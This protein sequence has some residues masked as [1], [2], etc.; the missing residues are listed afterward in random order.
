MPLNKIALFASSSTGTR[1]VSCCGSSCKSLQRVVLRVVLSILSAG[2]ALVSF[3]WAQ[4]RPSTQ[5][6]PLGENSTARWIEAYRRRPLTFEVNRG[7]TDSRVRFLSRRG[8]F[9]LFL[10]SNQAVIETVKPMGTLTSSAAGGRSILTMTWMGANRHPKIEGIG[11]TQG[12]TNYLV[13]N[14]PADWHTGIPSYTRVQYHEIYRGVDVTYYSEGSQLEYDLLLSPGSHPE[15]IGLRFS[16]AANPRLSPAGDL[17]LN[18]GSGRVVLH[19]PVV[20]QKT[21]SGREIISAKYVLK[22]RNQIGFKIGTYNHARALVIDPELTYSSYLGGSGDDDA[23]RV[24]VDPDGNA[25]LVGWSTSLDFP[26]ANPFQATAAGSTNA[27]I[28]KLNPEL[29]GSASLVYSTYLGGSG[30]NIGRGVAVDS[31][32][33]VY[34]SG[35]TNAADFPVTTGAYQTSCKLQGGTCSTDVFATKLNAA[36]NALLYSTYVGGSGTEFGFVVAI[37]GAGHIFLGGNTDSSDFPVT[38]GAYQTTF[39]GGPANYGDAFVAELNPAGNGASDLLYASYLGGSG[40][41]ATWGIAVDSLGSVYLAGSTTSSDFPVT[42]S[43]YQSTYSGGSSSVG[44]GFIAKLNPAGLGKS[45]LMYSTF[46]GGSMDDRVEGIALDSS[47]LVYVTGYTQ[48]SDFPVTPATAFQPTFGGGACFGAPCADA[49]I[50]KLDPSEFGSSS[51]LYS[52]FFG[53]SS[54]DL[55]HAIALDSTGL[56][57][58]TGETT[59]TDL[60]LTNPIQTQCASGCTPL[61]LT[62]VLIAKLDLSKPGTS[63]LLFSTYLGGND[64]DTGWSIAADSKGNAYVAGQLYSTNFPTVIPYQATCNGCSSFIGSSPSGDGFL[65]K[66]CT[67][68]CPAVSLSPASLTFSSQ[69]VETTSP[70]QELTLTNS[71]SGDLTVASIS[72]AGSN[73]EDFSQN[74][75]CPVVLSSDANCTVSVTFTPL[76]GGNRAASLMFSDN[77]GGSQSVSLSGIGAVSGPAVS[78]APGSLSFGD[79][80]LNSTSTGQAVTLTNEGPGALTITSIG[81]TGANPGDYGQSNNCPMSPSTLAANAGCTINMT[82]TP[83]ASGARSALLSITDDGEGSPQAVGLSGTGVVPTRPPWP[84]GYTYEGTFT[85]AAGQVPSTQTNFPV[86]IS[87]TFG[88]FATVGNGGKIVNTCQQTV[89]ND[90]MAVPCDLIFTSDAA[91]TKLLSWEYESYNAATGTATTW[92]NVPSLSN[93]T[94]IYAWY[95]NSAV[96]TV[97]TTPAAVWGS[98]FEGVYHLGEDPS[99]AAPQMNDSTGNANNVTMNGTLQSNEQQPGKVGGSLNIAGAD[100]WGSMAN[101]GNFGFERTDSFSI[102]GWFKMASNSYGALVSKVD[103]SSE[104]GWGLFQYATAT[105]PRFSLGLIGDGSTKNFAMVATGP[106]STGVWH[107]VVATYAGTSTVAGMKIYVDGVSQPLT[108]ILDSLS[109]SILNNVTPAINAQGGSGVSSDALD[110]IRVWA[111]GVVLSPDWVATSY[112]NQNNPAAFFTSATGLTN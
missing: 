23:A 5:S 82:F 94:V 101:P 90:E 104:T 84:N 47:N 40:S 100:A 10:T 49:F 44:D 50:A 39:G 69:N 61:P 83:T 86:V 20:Y 62:D 32:G 78:V 111:K 12:H 42:A 107:Y 6:G 22:S 64:V 19:R 98:R 109:E 29:P 11:E 31:L 76:V 112:N 52:T 3:T 60:P 34:V 91:G 108:T 73:S 105:T 99:G 26:T 79:Q 1:C 45:D 89:G 63:G 35:D 55:G 14:N 58:I 7:Q 74:N 71:G 17:I 75:N 87:G 80:T 25:Y 46:F 95:G 65:V 37:D 66:I 97:Q 96:T 54:I 13:G 48:S 56:V 102:S 57:Y 110:E 77:V 28:A 16:G 43:G 30:T 15:R 8:S 85:V 72:I 68:D 27:F 103:G 51:L 67:M 4:A 70:E 81:I 53:G 21:A 88:D 18:S 2:L 36:G 59:S 92:V 9:T 41:E 106:F 38:T 24:A 93:G 33:Q